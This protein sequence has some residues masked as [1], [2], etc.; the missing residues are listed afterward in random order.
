[1]LIRVSTV[2][3]KIPAILKDMGW[4][5]YKLH[6]VQ[7][8]FPVTMKLVN[9]SLSGMTVQMCYTTLI[10]SDEAVFHVVGFGNRINCHYCSGKDKKTIVECSQSTKTAYLVWNYFNPTQWTLHPQWTRNRQRCLEMLQNLLPPKIQRWHNTDEMIF[11]ARW[12][13]ATLPD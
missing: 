5:P 9:I 7:Q 6:D 4:Q 3:L 1:M 8:L 13:P 10:W 11:Y 12:C 2:H